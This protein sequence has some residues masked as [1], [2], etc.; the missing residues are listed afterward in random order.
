MVIELRKDCCREHDYRD[1]REWFC[2]QVDFE[3]RSLALL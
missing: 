2:A 1:Q 3:D